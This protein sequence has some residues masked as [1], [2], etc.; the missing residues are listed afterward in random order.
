M[1]QNLACIRITQRVC[2]KTDSRPPHPS[3]SRF[4]LRRSR[5]RSRICISNQLPSDANTVD[6]WTSLW[7]VLL[8]ETAYWVSAPFLNSCYETLLIFFQ[9]NRFT[10]PCVDSMTTSLHGLLDYRR[11]P[12]PSWTNQIFPLGNLWLGRGDASSFSAGFMNWIV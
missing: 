3:S 4:W 7:V 8:R 6:A 11:M 5:V 10:W 9:N 2:V 1:L 12:D